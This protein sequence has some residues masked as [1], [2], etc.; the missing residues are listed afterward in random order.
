MTHPIRIVKA[1]DLKEN[2]NQE[3]VWNEI[4]APWKH[5]R[6]KR[7]YVVVEFLENKK[8]KIIDMGCGEGRNMVPNH[9]EYYGVDFSQ[10]QL[11]QARRRLEKDKI[12]AHLFKSDLSKLPPEFKDN[13]FDHGLF[14]ATLHCIETKSKRKK[15]LEELYRVL[16]KGGE[17]LITVWNSEDS[18]FKDVGKGD[19]YMAW[20]VNEINQMRYYYLY[21]KQEFLDLLK[22]VG[23]KI[24][25][26]WKPRPNDRFTK[27]NYIVSVRK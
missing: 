16:K 8:G 11:T 13:M 4:S 14:I 17:A 22:S 9:K 27:K 20:P 19:I 12:K 6:S 1:K 7:I 3:K 26:I 21:D 25:E 24:L 10:G 15:S 2:P 23:F 18:R 5:Y